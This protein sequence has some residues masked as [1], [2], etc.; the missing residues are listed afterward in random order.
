M[1]SKRTNVFYLIGFITALLFFVMLAVYCINVKSFSATNHFYVLF[2]DGGFTLLVF[3]FLLFGG[4]LLKKTGH[5]VPCFTGVLAM[6]V[7]S[8]Y[9]LVEILNHLFQDD[10]F[11]TPANAA[12]S[13]INLFLGIALVGGVVIMIVETIT[14]IRKGNGKMLTKMSFIARFLV[15]LMLS[16]VSVDLIIN[17]IKTIQGTE[18]F[19][20]IIFTIALLSLELSHHQ[21]LDC[22]GDIGVEAGG[23][24]KFT[25]NN[26]LL[27]IIVFA[28]LFAIIPMNLYLVRT[29]A[30]DMTL[31]VFTSIFTVIGMLALVLGYS[32][33]KIY[34]TCFLIGF[35]YVIAM[36]VIVLIGFLH[37]D[38]KHHIEDLGLFITFNLIGLINVP[39]FSSIFSIFFRRR[40]G[41]KDIRELLN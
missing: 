36:I 11:I 8:V 30:F 5:L 23:E 22:L 14:F 12:N 29:H 24:E 37:F 13:I 16:K 40:L 19:V 26:A 34:E 15:V 21:L 3:A 2:I 20:V 4:E 9:E 7:S 31:F 10:A 1:F 33:D 41:K 6:S 27:L 38:Y 17:I 35:A 18:N 25:N 32:I 28:V 39:A